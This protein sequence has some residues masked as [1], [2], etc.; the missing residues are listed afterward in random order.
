M[1]LDLPLRISGVGRYLPERVV[2]SRD[3]ERRCGLPAGWAERRAGV[4]TRRWADP[5]RETAA[6]MGAWAA[7]EALEDAGLGPRDLDLILGASGTPQQPIP[8][9]AALIQ[10][11][12]GLGAS[13]IPAFSVHATCLSFLTA[14]QVAA[15]L[16]ASGTYRRI[17]VVSSE[18]A[19]V[20]LNFAQPE[21]A[22]LMGD[23][24]AAVVLERARLGHSS[25]LLAARFETYGDGAHLTEI[26]GGGSAL[27]PLSPAARPEDFTFR[28]EGLRVLRM[29][30]DLSGAFL[31]ALRPGLSQ[32]LAGL[33]A[34]V[35]HQASRAGL[36]LLSRYGWPERAVARTL[37]HLGNCVAASIP[38]TLYD[39]LR[40]GEVQRGDELLLVGTGAGFSMG[41]VILRY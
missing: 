7:L 17:L 16:L 14:L 9:G 10:R 34:V 41:G 12:L 40:S 33:R 38:A 23:A 4:I 28:M 31:E 18:V 15:H 29:A 13:G 35:P 32:G 24:A 1:D 39:L 6:R 5:H 8:D 20:G 26:R 27:P 22:V 25:A 21:S 37:P 19:S 30:R 11:E 36:E 3:L 2:H